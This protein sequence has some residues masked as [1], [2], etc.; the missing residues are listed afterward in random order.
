M[1]DAVESGCSRSRVHEPLFLPHHVALWMHLR[2]IHTRYPGVLGFLPLIYRFFGQFGDNFSP[3][4][5][6]FSTTLSSNSLSH[7]LFL[8]LFPFMQKKQFLWIQWYYISPLFAQ[9]ETIVKNNYLLFNQAIRFYLARLNLRYN[10]T[11]YYL[12]ENPI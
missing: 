11:S 8:P 4:G 9:W 3:V 12:V 6:R 10:Q 2:R 7:S 1:P 5:I